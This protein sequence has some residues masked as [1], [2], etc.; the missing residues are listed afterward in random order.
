MSPAPTRTAASLGTA[1]GDAT[2]PRDG[3]ASVRGKLSR[4]RCHQDGERDE[5]A[6]REDGLTSFRVHRLSLE[7]FASGPRR[8]PAGWL[9]MSRSGSHVASPT[10]AA[11]G[12]LTGAL[13]GEASNRIDSAAGR[14][15]AWPARAPGSQQ[16]G[17]DDPG[18]GGPRRPRRPGG[19]L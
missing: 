12:D 15:S 6:D 14:H 10:C 11:V 7:R 3:I 5:H 2:G 19:V 16:P 1:G 9:L 18:G 17:D 13:T 4:E 8:R